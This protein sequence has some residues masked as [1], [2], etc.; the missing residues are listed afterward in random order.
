[1]QVLEVVHLVISTIPN[2][3]L[4]PICGSTETFEIAL[5]RQPI[6]LWWQAVA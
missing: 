2:L 1:M 5:A 4:G 3:W 6:F